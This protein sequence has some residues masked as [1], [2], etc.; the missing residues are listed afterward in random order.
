MVND[1]RNPF[2][3]RQLVP[4]IQSSLRHTYHAIQYLPEKL[5]KCYL[6]CSHSTFG[7]LSNC[8]S[9]PL[10]V[11]FSFKDLTQFYTSKLQRFSSFYSFF[12]PTRLNCQLHIFRCLEKRTHKALSGN[13]KYWNKMRS[14]RGLWSGTDAMFPVSL[15]ITRVQNLQC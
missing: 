3:N 15:C 10:S 13:S 2:Y 7:L 11:A 6:P 1:F 9:S 12:L 5:H 8:C 4:P 14:K